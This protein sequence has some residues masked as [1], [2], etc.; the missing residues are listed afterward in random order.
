[1][2]GKIPETRNA[3]KRRGRLW[4]KTC[5]TLCDSIGP[6]TFFMPPCPR[7]GVQL[8]KAPGPKP[9]IALSLHPTLP[10]WCASLRLDRCL[11][12]I[13]EEEIVHHN[14]RFYPV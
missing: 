14:R 9:E 8:K 2:R 5:A 3:S 11:R 4:C 12:L 1:M 7:A 13:S 10:T 6:K